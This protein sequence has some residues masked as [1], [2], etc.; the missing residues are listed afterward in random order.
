[1]CSCT[2]GYFSPTYSVRP[3]PMPLALPVSHNW[4]RP[5]ENARNPDGID[6][7]EWRIEVARSAFDQWQCLSQ[8]EGTWTAPSIELEVK[9]EFHNCY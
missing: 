8:A 7:N 4:H 5:E 9:A 2:I 6:M 3:S 1:M